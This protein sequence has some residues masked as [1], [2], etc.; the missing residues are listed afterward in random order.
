[1]SISK[2]S[3]RDTGTKACGLRA[4]F[5]FGCSRANPISQCLRPHAVLSLRNTYLGR[6]HGSNVDFD[7]TESN[8]FASE[9]FNVIERLVSKVNIT[10]KRKGKLSIRC[11]AARC[12]QN[13]I[14]KCSLKAF[15]CDYIPVVPSW[16]SHA[17]T[18]SHGKKRW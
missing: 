10:G 5:S 16:F 11:S 8:K 18:R 15:R 13:L 7:G 17:K 9:F 14:K 6:I 12:C 3:S 1:M 2:T 4:F